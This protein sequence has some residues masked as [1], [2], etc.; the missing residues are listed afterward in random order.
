[1]LEKMYYLSDDN[2]IPQ[3]IETT[4]LSLDEIEYLVGRFNKVSS[5]TGKLRGKVNVYF[6][7]KVEIRHHFTNKLLWSN[8]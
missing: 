6:N 2:N 7:G 5:R 4:G 8:R 3:A 1:M